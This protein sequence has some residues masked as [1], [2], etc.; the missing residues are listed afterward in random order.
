MCCNYATLHL[1]KAGKKTPQTTFK[2]RSRY[3]MSLS[4]RF[5]KQFRLPP[6]LIRFLF[7][8]FF[9]RYLQLCSP[10]LNTGETP[11]DPVFLSFGKQYSSDRLRRKTTYMDRQLMLIYGRNTFRFPPW[12]WHFGK[13]FFLTSRRNRQILLIC[14]T[15]CCCSLVVFVSLHSNLF[16][17]ESIFPVVCSVPMPMYSLNM[18]FPHP[19]LCLE[20]PSSLFGAVVTM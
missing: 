8:F 10:T 2:C 15:H 6:F 16:I 3:S 12:T 19:R 7:S 4:F 5:A 20:A 11:C 13:Y 1:R 18:Y 14:L 17:Y 9:S